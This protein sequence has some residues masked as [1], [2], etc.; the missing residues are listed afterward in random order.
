M[1]EAMSVFIG[2]GKFDNSEAFS[3]ALVPGASITLTEGVYLTGPI[4]LPSDVTL[5]IEKGATLKFIPEFD[6][7]EPVYSRWEGVKCY[8]MHPCIFIP[9]ARNVTV[10]GEGT[11]DGSGQAFWDYIENGD[12]RHTRVAP[13]LPIEKKLAALNPGYLDQPGGGG[14][15]YCQFLR[16]PLFQPLRSDN[17]TLEGVH[18]IDSPF[19]TIHPVFS[20]NLTFKGVSIKNP[21][22]APNTDGFDIDSCTNVRIIDCNVDVGDDGIC[23]KSGSG[24]DGIA[25]KAPTAHV[26]VEGC[27]VHG[28]HG[29]I[30]LGSETASGIHDVVARNCHFLGTDRGIR[31]KSRRGR[32]GTLENLEF[33]NLHMDRNFCP[34]TCYLWYR[35]GAPDPTLPLYE[36]KAHPVTPETP[37]IRNLK[38]RNCTG[39]NATASAMLIAGLPESPIENVEIENC[40]FAVDPNTTVD[41]NEADMYLGLGTPES[42][43][44]RLKW[45]K[46]LKLDNVTISGVEGK[47]IILEEGCEDIR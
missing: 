14:G 30:V 36:Q 47:Q 25:D 1:E 32:G 11:I 20:N 2:D 31:I 4:T 21:Y 45:V 13:T 44:A 46:S 24:S 37:H 41:V 35:G 6:R 17:V 3:K 43:G 10:R 39:T 18:I 8:C 26:H 12:K 27:T 7:Y 42:R 19:W 33:E 38:I 9:D 16:P 15:R 28:A 40:T 5:T 29:G 22:L 23:L 34:F